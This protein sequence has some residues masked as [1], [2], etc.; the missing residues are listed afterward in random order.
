MARK[1]KKEVGHCNCCGPHCVFFPQNPSQVLN[2]QM[3][4]GVKHRK[5][6]RICRC[7]GGVISSWSSGENKCELYESI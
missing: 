5:V 1:K 4:G 7:D 3:V 6:I 2:E